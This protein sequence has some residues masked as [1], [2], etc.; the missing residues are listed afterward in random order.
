MIGRR[1]FALNLLVNPLR[2][3]YVVRRRIGTY[4]KNILGI[5]SVQ[6]NEVTRKNE[7]IAQVWIERTTSA[8]TIVPTP[9]VGFLLVLIFH[10]GQKGHRAHR[11]ERRNEETKGQRDGRREGQKLLHVLHKTSAI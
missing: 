1:S 3:F 10:R 7:K 2:Y 9:F 8:F 6:Y 5:T 11:I 4:G